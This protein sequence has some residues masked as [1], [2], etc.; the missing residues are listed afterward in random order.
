MLRSFFYSLFL[1]FPIGPSFA[2]ELFVPTKPGTLLISRNADER[3][4]TSP[5][6]WNHWAFWAGDLDGDGDAD[7]LES[8]EGLGVI[9]TDYSVFLSRP[10]SRII[11]REPTNLEFG[12]RYIQVADSKVGLPHRTF[13]SIRGRDTERSLRKGVSCI[14]LVRYPVREVG[15]VRI[16]RARIPDRHTLLAKKGL[17]GPEIVVR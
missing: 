14:T 9:R 1:L 16:R 5:G 8:Q 2:Q 6:Y 11:A 15:G 3:L 17:F 12:V 7:V 13:A 10:Y 4:N